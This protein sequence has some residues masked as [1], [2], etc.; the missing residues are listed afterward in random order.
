MRKLV[1]LSVFICLIF[2]VFLVH[3]HAEEKGKLQSYHYTF[4]VGSVDFHG[5]VDGELVNGSF[6]YPITIDKEYGRAGY[7]VWFNCPTNIDFTI[8]Y[9]SQTNK[10]YFHFYY[11][12]DDLLLI[13]PD[14][15]ACVNNKEIPIGYHI[16]KLQR[17]NDNAEY[18]GKKV[19]HV[20]TYL[21]PL[22]LVFE[23]TGHKVDWN[24]DT[25]EITVTYPAPEAE[26]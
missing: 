8:E 24:P 15:T 18:C 14:Q 17:T 25:Q 6:L 12:N 1:L 13:H 19:S 21:I 22:R 2:S 26:E 20:I 9:E 11:A 23:F 7:D 3:T 10:A 5:V 4:K 16:E